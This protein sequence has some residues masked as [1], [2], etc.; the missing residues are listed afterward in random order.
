MRENRKILKFHFLPEKRA[1]SGL[2]HI[3]RCAIATF[4]GVCFLRKVNLLNIFMRKLRFRIFET[5]M[6]LHY[7]LKNPKSHFFPENIDHI[8]FSQKTYPPKCAIAHLLVYSRPILAIFSGHKLDFKICMFSSIIK[9]VFSLSQT[10][11]G[12]GR[13]RNS[14]LD[15]ATDLQ[16]SVLCKFPFWF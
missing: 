15:G 14:P 5:I 6:E 2:E 8:H 4:W 16:Q 9:S 12:A 11:L 13:H 10:Y 1:I 3:K 7:N